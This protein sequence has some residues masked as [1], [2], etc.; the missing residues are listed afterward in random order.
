MPAPSLLKSVL[1]LI[2]ISLSLAFAETAFAQTLAGKE[3]K[4]TEVLAQANAG[5]ADAQNLLGAM[6]QTGTTVVRS[7]EEAARWYAKAAEQGHAASQ[8]NLGAMYFDG[9]G[10]QVSSTRAVELYKKSAAQQLPLG[11][12]RLGAAYLQ[13]WGIEQDVKKGTELLTKA[14]ELGVGLAAYEFGRAHLYGTGAVKDV[15]LAKTWFQKS[16]QLGYP[17]GQFVYARDYEADK[18]KKIDLFHKAA[19]GGHAG[20]QYHLGMYYADKSSDLYDLDKAIHWYSLAALNG[21]EMGNQARFKLGLPDVNGRQPVNT[22]VMTSSPSAK[23]LD[24]HTTV[25]LFAA[26]AGIAILLGTAFSSDGNAA[27][28]NSSSYNDE[29]KYCEPCSYGEREVNDNQCQNMDTGALTS[30]ICR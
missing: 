10:V 7:D 30:R 18:S 24:G 21:N 28:S 3:L 27:S 22:K 2:A 13:G 17:N 19:L 4:F 23:E 20:A 16:A 1:S 25:A 15:M 12:A 5:D 26:A 8:A 9:K 29:R 11:I 14:V 6:Y